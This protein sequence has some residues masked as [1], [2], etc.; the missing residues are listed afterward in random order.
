M[1]IG[2][3]GKR[4][5]NNVTGLGNY[6][7]SLIEHLA[8]Q[9]P[10]N[11]YYVYTPKINDALKKHPLFSR[12]NV[13]LELPPKN[14][15]SPIWRSVGIVLQLIKNK[16]T[17]YHGLSH[18]IPYGLKENGI[19]SVVTIHD[20]IFLVKPSYY[21]FVDRIIYKYK[22][23]YAC[24]HA[25]KIIAISEQTK[26]DIIQFYKADP[27]KIEVIYQTCDDQFKTLVGENEKA[28]LRKKHKLP[29]NYLLNVGTIETRKNLLLLI[30]AL[31]LIDPA[32]PLVVIGKETPYLKTIQKEIE[33]L[34]L[35]NRVIFL[36]DVPFQDFP[37]LYQMASSFIYPSL[38][39]GFG[40]PIIEALYGKVPVIAATGSCLEEAGGPDSVY[41]SPDD[42]VSLAKAINLV[43]SDKNLQEQMKIKGLAYVQKF[44]SETVSTQ[45]MNCYLNT[46]NPEEIN[47]S[48]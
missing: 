2:F 7:R 10:E 17:L 35:Q 25:D 9:F 15:T 36:K 42:H 32:Y 11:Q 47:H 38:Y 31:P 21:S 5:A 12:D 48:N 28:F 37:G 27:A 13:K 46:I 45:L 30:K 3:D 44:N 6:S 41:V 16:I 8:T 20:L 40:I 43:L 29:P 22:S 24:K 39:E 23:K 33:A 4:A 19:K 1:K 18:E 34:A 26:K 14:S